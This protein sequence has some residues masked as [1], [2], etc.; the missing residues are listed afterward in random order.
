MPNRPV[1]GI[2]VEAVSVIIPAFNA[3]RFL[4][5]A[6]ESVLAQDLPVEIVVVND[7]SSDAT[8]SVAEGLPVTLIDQANGGTAAAVN[9]GI[10]RATGDRLAFVDADDRWTIG[11]LAAQLRVLDESD[12]VDAVFGQVRHFVD[13]E[14]AGRFSVP[15]TVQPGWTRATMLVRR[16]AFERIGPFR[17]TS[18]YSENVEWHLR[19]TR[20]GLVMQ[21][22]D[23][24]VLERRLHGANKTLSHPPELVR[25]RLA[26]LREHLR[27]RSFR[28]CGR[29]LTAAVARPDGMH[30]V[31]LLHRSPWSGRTGPGIIGWSDRGGRLVET[32]R[33][34]CSQDRP[35]RDRRRGA[36][37]PRR[38]R[39]LPQH[40]GTGRCD[41]VDRSRR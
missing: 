7:G 4:A 19:A 30:R 20:G 2:G 23:L 26:I 6:V 12:E 38:D 10:E 13:P 11:R 8:R 31:V 9:A 17:E 28:R 33:A 15:R 24:V 3:E 39:Q 1:G 34:P 32:L 16:S 37:H 5:E 40:A 29:R 14:V 25:S 35:R 36:G 21:M 22:L 41:L 27:H 18:L